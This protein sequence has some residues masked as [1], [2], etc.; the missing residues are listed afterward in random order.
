MLL[1]DCLFRIVSAGGKAAHSS[2]A[3]LPRHLD[4]L[5]SASSRRLASQLA[6]MASVITATPAASTGKL[7]QNNA[8]MAPA[9]AIRGSQDIRVKRYP[10]SA[11]A[12]AP[13]ARIAITPFQISTGQGPPTMTSGLK[14]MNSGIR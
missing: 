13:R 6:P 11:A 3:A 2:P 4:R 10:S 12:K 8:T 9:M 1:G 7:G 5:D 14:T